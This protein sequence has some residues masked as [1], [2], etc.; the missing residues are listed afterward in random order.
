MQILSQINES[1]TTNLPYYQQ[2]TIYAQQGYR[3]GVMTF[4]Q[5]CKQS[6]DGYQKVVTGS[7]ELKKQAW[8]LAD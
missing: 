2:A 1:C 4:N 5:I 3:H 7:E 6:T 8:E